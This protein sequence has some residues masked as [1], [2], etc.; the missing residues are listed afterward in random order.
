MK[1][2]RRVVEFCGLRTWTKLDIFRPME[3]E[4]DEP[5]SSGVGPAPL[6]ATPDAACQVL[7]DSA[8]KLADTS[9]TCEE[10]GHTS[11][12]SAFDVLSARQRE[13]VTLLAGG[14]STK[15]VAAQLDVG[16]KTI[17]S[18]RAAALAKLG[19]S[20]VAELTKYAV[21]EGLTGL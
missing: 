8:E 18:H 21:R 10:T 13:V 19:M 15:E 20:G 2:F 4:D 1:A 16:V 3:M 6:I 9:K 5:N 14:L 12:R 17:E 11:D 7:K